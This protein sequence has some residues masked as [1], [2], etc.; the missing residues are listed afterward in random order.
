MTAREHAE[1]AQLEVIDFHFLRD[2]LHFWA[3]RI[4]FDADASGFF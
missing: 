1:V 2:Y 4:V 3:F